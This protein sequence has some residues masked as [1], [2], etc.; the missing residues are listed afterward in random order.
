MSGLFSP[1][2]ALIRGLHAAEVLAWRALLPDRFTRLEIES[3]TRCNRRCAFCPVSLGPR[4]DHDMPQELFLSILDQAD[5]MG[6]RGR[7]SPHFYNEPL[8]DPRL[9]SLLREVRARLP[10]AFIVLY[11]N[12]DALGP[13]R[14]RE[15][16]DA[17][18]FFFIVT[19]EGEEGPA[20]RRAR[21]ALGPWA[22]RRRV[23]V[24]QL[25]EGSPE[26]YNRGGTVL[27]GVR[28]S[29][30]G[31]CVAAASTLVVD[32]WGRVRLCFN[33][34]LGERIWGDLSREP[35]LD[36][37]CKPDYV[38]FRRDLLEGRFESATCRACNG[39]PMEEEPRGQAAP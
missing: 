34:Y 8:L 13:E 25:H 33:D 24:R 14:L 2:N 28:P 27:P 9:S 36:V 29:G 4:P 7:F 12:G 23:L 17:G 10:G 30:R 32:A 35:L 11:T 18:V 22:F 20:L 6:F 26:L 31:A 39:L 38:R 5:R 1:R 37:W 3:S 19:I 21:E 16:L 15:L